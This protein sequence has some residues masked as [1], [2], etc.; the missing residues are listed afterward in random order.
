MWRRAWKDSSSFFGWN[1]RTFTVPLFLWLMGAIIFYQWQGKEAVL[2][3]VVVAISF[4]L[5]PVGVFLILLYLFHLIRAPIY[6]KWEKEKQPKLTVREVVRGNLSRTQSSWGVLV[7]N[8]GT[9]RADDCRGEIIYLEFATPPKG[10]SMRGWPINQPLQWA[11]AL[12]GTSSINI[13]GSR[14]AVLQ[15]IVGD[16]DELCIA[17]AVSEAFRN[18]HAIHASNDF[19][20]GIAITSKDTTPVYAVVFIVKRAFGGLV[21]KMYILEITK[22]KPTEQDYHQIL[23]EHWEEIER[24][25]NAIL[26]PE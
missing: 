22:N 9:S 4:T 26:H 15:V 1:K 11:Q 23:D 13:P 10:L 7:A 3:E 8:Q 17:Y 12:T 20:A 16:S 24:N 21:T 5:I 18:D 2:E 6:M 19:I 25:V 14:D